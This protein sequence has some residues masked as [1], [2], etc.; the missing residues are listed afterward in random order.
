MKSV[1]VALLATQTAFA[2]VIAEATSGGITVQ[3]HDE[4]GVCVGRA[5]HAVYLD[6]QQRIPGC[7][8]AHED[9]II[10]VF[11]DTDIANIPHA[12]FRKPKEV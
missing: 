12:A 8:V 2:G 7:W 3:L 4:V 9:R 1:L 10:I 6:G 5:R 11:L